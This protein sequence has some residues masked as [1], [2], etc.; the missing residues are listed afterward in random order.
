MAEREP[1]ALHP[2]PAACGGIKEDIDKMIGQ[3]IHLIDIENAAVC[4]GE[5]AWLKT[6]GALFHR[7]LDIEGPYN[8]VLGG[9]HG[10]LDQRHMSDVGF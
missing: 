3:Q 2:V 10:E 8:S 6:A 1:F 4:R 9:G 7:V 5:D